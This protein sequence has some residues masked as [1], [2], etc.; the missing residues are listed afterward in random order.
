MTN[1]VKAKSTN[2]KSQAVMFSFRL[3]IQFRFLQRIVEVFDQVLQVARFTDSHGVSGSMW[4][5]SVIQ[6]YIREES[7]IPGNS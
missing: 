1:Y 2:Q 6:T 5:D 4:L 7:R 3:L